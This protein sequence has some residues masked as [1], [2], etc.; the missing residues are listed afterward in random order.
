MKYTSPIGRIVQG[1]GLVGNPQFIKG[2]TTPKLGKNGQ[3]SVNWY[4]NVAFEKANPKTGEMIQ[5]I[6]TEAARLYPALFPYGYQAAARADTQPPLNAGGC[7]RNDF[8]IKVTDGDSYDMVSGKPHSAKEGWAGC[9]IVKVS[10]YAG[11]LRIVDGL[12]NNATITEVGNLPGQIKTG[13]FVICCLDINT[14]GW[15]G[16]AQSKPGIYMGAD[17]L[18]K[19]GNG[20]PIVSG[21]NVD[22]IL[23]D[24][25]TATGG[26]IP[27]GMTTTPT[28]AALPGA[29]GLPAPLQPA[30][31]AG[32]LPVISSANAL[33]GLPAP[34]QAAAA[35]QYIIAPEAAAAGHT[36]AALTALGHTDD[37]LIANGYL[38]LAPTA[39]ALP[40]IAPVVAAAPAL[41]VIPNHG[42][43]TAVLATPQ[44][45]CTPAVL[46]QGHTLASLQAAGHTIDAL[47][48]AQYITRV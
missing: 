37:S 9:W 16:D 26:Y 5:A 27:A 28:V 35:P 31:S 24:V 11:A 22:E 40:A 17:L 45:A 19:T 10:T 1:N 21:P 7:I 25:A 44:Y 13:D 23:R 12:N 42:V 4:V 32:A 48:A 6:F 30:G 34:L 15:S 43:V 38:V 29:V 3:Q 36:H 47:L 33:P 2:T 18:Q 14:N 8:A 20:D 41:P 39:P 46:A